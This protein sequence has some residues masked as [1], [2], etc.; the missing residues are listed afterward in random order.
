[1]TGKGRR[2]DAGEFAFF[3]HR[4][5][6]LRDPERRFQLTRDDFALLN[7]N[8]RTCPIF[9]T[10]RDMEITKKIYQRVPVL[11][12]ESKGEEGNPWGVQFRQGLFNMTSDS[13]LFRTREQMEADGWS[14]TG[15]LFRRGRDRYLPL[16]EAKLIHQ[17]DHRWATYLNDDDTRDLTSRE[18]NNP[19]RLVMPRYWVGERNVE[20]V[21]ENRCP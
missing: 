20:Q 12:D 13:S 9:R 11:M 17:F 21:L 19:D 2:Q 15:N 6:Q 16:Y 5:D 4:A 18:K 7:P 3:L 1:L 8:T 10:K 14:L